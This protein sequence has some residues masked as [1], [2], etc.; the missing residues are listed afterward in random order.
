MDPCKDREPG[1]INNELLE[2]CIRQQ[3][4]PGEA[5]RLAQEEG[6]PLEEIEQLRL[7]HLSKKSSIYVY[8]FENSK[9]VCRYFAN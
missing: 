2:K 7:E 4:P 8:I 5:G 1:V 9:I 6:V 3:F